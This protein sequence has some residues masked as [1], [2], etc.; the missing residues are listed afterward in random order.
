M[1]RS[2]VRRAAGGVAAAVVVGVL[3]GPQPA[4]A[5]ITVDSAVCLNNASGTVTSPNPVIP[6]GAIFSNDYPMLNWQATIETTYCRQANVSLHLVRNSEFSNPLHTPGSGRV[7][8]PGLYLLRVSTSLGA[9]D[10]ASIRI[11]QG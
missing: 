9:K 10:V 1:N 11:T 2:H 6:P 8:D 5:D 4:N 7:F 3:V